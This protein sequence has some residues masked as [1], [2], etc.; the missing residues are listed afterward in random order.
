MP[1]GYSF[2]TVRSEKSGRRES[3]LFFWPMA[4]PIRYDF[5]TPIRVAWGD[6]DALRHVNNVSYT[7]YFETARAEFFVHLHQTFDYRLPENVT[8]ILTRLEF[9]YRGQV[10]FPAEL[11]VRVGIVA[12]TTRTMS[13]GCSMWNTDGKCVGDGVSD[14]MWIDISTGRAIRRPAEFQPVADHYEQESLKSPAN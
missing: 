14:H 8:L 1:G 6:M 9:N 11:E 2:L 5:V 10:F 3:G 7:R 4:Q 13:L 12:L